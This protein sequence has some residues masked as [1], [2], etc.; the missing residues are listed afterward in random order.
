MEPSFWTFAEVQELKKITDRPGDPPS[1]AIG[2]QASA[3]RSNPLPA[4]AETPTD[5]F[6]QEISIGR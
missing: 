1:L 2:C 6:S 3:S 4:D 5:T